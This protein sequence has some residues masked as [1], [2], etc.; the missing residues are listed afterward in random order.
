MQ[1]QEDDTGGG[2]VDVVAVKGDGLIGKGVS[3]QEQTG[4]QGAGR[5]AP[6]PPGEQGQQGSVEAVLGDG[7]AMK[8]NG[9]IVAENSFDDE[10][11]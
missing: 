3:G 8:Q 2:W 6:Q 10:K 4:G 5:A 9:R 11:G 7:Q 1:G